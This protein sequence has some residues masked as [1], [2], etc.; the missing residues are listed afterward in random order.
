METGTLDFSENQKVIISSDC[1]FSSSVEN[2]TL[3]LAREMAKK[4]LKDLNLTFTTYYYSS[5][6]LHNKDEIVVPFPEKN[7]YWEKEKKR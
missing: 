3:H 6:P 7:I 5:L 1:G 4:S 2:F